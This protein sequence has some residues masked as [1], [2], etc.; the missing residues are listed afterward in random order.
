MLAPSTES[1]ILRLRQ[2]NFGSIFQNERFKSWYN[3]LSSETCEFRYMS[4]CL[5]DRLEPPLSV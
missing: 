4:E 5:S 1:T 3:T 2:Y